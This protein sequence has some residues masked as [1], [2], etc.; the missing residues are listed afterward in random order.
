LDRSST[1]FSGGAAVCGLFA[2]HFSGGA[3]DI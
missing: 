3:T 2:K 1:L